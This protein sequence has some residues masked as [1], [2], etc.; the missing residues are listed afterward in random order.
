MYDPAYSTG[1]NR[2]DPTG[3][4]FLRCPDRKGGPT[5][6]IHTFEESVTVLF[7]GKYSDYT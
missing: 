6:T 1:G 7:P 5:D 4:L 3:D 2:L